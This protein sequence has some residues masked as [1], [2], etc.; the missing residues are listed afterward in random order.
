MRFLDT[1]DV[2]STLGRAAYSPYGPHLSIEGNRLLADFI[3]E[4]LL[5][6]QITPIPPVNLRE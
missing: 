6:L 2:V 1:T 3:E 5:T 4:Q